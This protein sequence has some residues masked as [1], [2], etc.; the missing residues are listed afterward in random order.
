MT[1]KELLNKFPDEFVCDVCTPLCRTCGMV[2]HIKSQFN[3]E[4]IVDFW[5]VNENNTLLINL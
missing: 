5:K 3:L 4:R 2:K 1:L